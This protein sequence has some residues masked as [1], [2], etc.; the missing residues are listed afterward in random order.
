M[1]FLLFYI[2]VSPQVSMLTY[3]CDKF[4]LKRGKDEKGISAV[5]SGGDLR[6]FGWIDRESFMKLMVVF[7]EV[8]SIEFCGSLW[9]EFSGS[10]W[11]LQVGTQSGKWKYL[12]LWR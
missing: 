4:I 3:L 9:V 7:V 2:F 11:I 1:S 6:G 5:I 8:L 10:L 12:K